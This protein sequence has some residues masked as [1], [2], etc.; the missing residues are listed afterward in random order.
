[1]DDFE[2][3][4]RTLSKIILPTSTTMIGVC[5]TIIGLVKVY[6]VRAGPSRVDEYSALVMLL[7][8]V[9]AIASYLSI[10]EAD[11]AGHGAR[12]ELLADVSFVLGLLGL[13]IVGFFFAY[14]LI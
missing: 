8:F 14:E 7:F 13:T 6:E 10:R 12:L 11:R 3:T 5:A 1:M 4:E 9:S 2:P